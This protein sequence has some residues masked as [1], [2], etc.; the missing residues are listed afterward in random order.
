MEDDIIQDTYPFNHGI[1]LMLEEQLTWLVKQ[2]NKYI[3]RHREDLKDKKPEALSSSFK[4]RVVWVKLV[5]PPDL[6]LEHI[7]K[8]R[9]VRARFNAH[10][11][12]ILLPE[13]YMHIMAITDVYDHPEKF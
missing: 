1:T 4:P 13:K 6:N 8:V 2:V 3:I 11:N 9:S 10:L 7:R 5:N 12:E